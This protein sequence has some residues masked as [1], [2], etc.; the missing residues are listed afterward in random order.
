MARARPATVSPLMDSIATV[1]TLVLFARQDH[2]HPFDTATVRNNAPQSLTA[3]Q[4]QQA[5]QNIYAAPFDA[6]AYS[7]LQIN[8]GMEVSQERGQLSAKC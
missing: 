6:M 8:G 4:Q 1:G 2:I 3:P 5:R 7:G